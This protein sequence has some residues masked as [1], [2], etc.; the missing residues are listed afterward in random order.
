MCKPKIEI[1]KDVCV[2]RENYFIVTKLGRSEE[3][4]K[5]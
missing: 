4:Y 3:R 5:S 2:F 1:N